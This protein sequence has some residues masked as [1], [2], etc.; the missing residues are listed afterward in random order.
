MRG[1]IVFGLG[2]KG[3]G[4]QEQC[5]SLTKQMDVFREASQGAVD[6]QAG[7]SKNTGL[8]RRSDCVQSCTF[9]PSRSVNY[10]MRLKSLKQNDFCRMR[11]ASREGGGIIVSSAILTANAR[12]I[13]SG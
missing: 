2:S 13:G 6:A 12:L 7:A 3:L 10:S 8:E 5:A 1:R 11:D 9:I 4:C